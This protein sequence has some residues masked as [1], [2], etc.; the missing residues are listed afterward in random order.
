MRTHFIAAAMMAIGCLHGLALAEQ[1]AGAEDIPDACR[2]DSD[3]Q[4]DYQACFD[5]AEPN[6]V[7]WML[8]AINLGSEAFW[9]DDVETAAHYYDLSTP[10]DQQIISDIILHANRADVFRRVGRPDDSLN[11]ARFAWQMV[12]EGRY[13]LKGNPLD[14]EAKLYVLQLIVQTF[15]EAAAPERDAVVRAYLD[16]P[17][18]TETDLANKVAVLTEIGRYDEALPL[19]GE[20]VAS[21]PEHFG[22]LNN[23]CYLLTLM[24]R[25][26]EGLPYCQ[27]AVALAPDV[28]SLQHSLAL[29]LAAAGRCEEAGAALAKAHALEPSVVKYA[30]PVACTAPE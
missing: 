6:S 25:A 20:L 15:D 9:N 13:D 14:D 28:A 29:A 24:G 23:H 2:Y 11:D 8:A 19:S 26:P 12:Q 18:R 5:A 30:E 3:D 17:V 7:I 21:L 16:T 4:I 10:D 27:K 22:V 1:A